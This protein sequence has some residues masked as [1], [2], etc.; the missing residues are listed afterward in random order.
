MKNEIGD[1]K[2]FFR[3]IKYSPGW[4]DDLREKFISYLKPKI[5]LPLYGGNYPEEIKKRIILSAFEYINKVDR[6]KHPSHFLQDPANKIPSAVTYSVEAQKVLSEKYL[7]CSNIAIL[8]QNLLAEFKIPTELMV[9]FIKN[10]YVKEKDEKLFYDERFWGENIRH[11]FLARHDAPSINLSDLIIDRSI[12]Y[13]GWSD[14]TLENLG[15][16]EARPIK[17]LSKEERILLEKE[18]KDRSTWTKN[19]MIFHKGQYHL[20]SEHQSLKNKKFDGKTLPIKSESEIRKRFFKDGFFDKGISVEALNKEGFGFKHLNR[21]I[22]ARTIGQPRY[23]LQKNN[24][25]PPSYFPSNRRMKEILWGF[26]LLIRNDDFP[27]LLTFLN[28]NSVFYIKSIFY[29]YGDAVVWI[30]IDREKHCLEIPSWLINI[31]KRG[32]DQFTLMIKKRE[33]DIICLDFGNDP[34]KVCQIINAI[35]SIV[36]KKIWDYIP[37]ARYFTIIEENVPG[38]KIKG[39]AAESRHILISRDNIFGLAA[40]YGK[41]GKDEWFANIG[42]GSRSLLIEDFYERLYREVRNLIPGSI[43]EYQEKVYITLVR[44]YRRWLQFI[45]KAKKDCNFERNVCA[46]D[47]QHVYNEEKNTLEPYLIEL[48]NHFHY[49]GLSEISPSAYGIVSEIM[50]EE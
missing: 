43:K 22:L 30:R 11:F 21:F 2:K 17:S 47:I 20:R 46:F 15:Y 42:K 28:A 24:L 49:D 27:G 5:D 23:I 40:E 26:P 18:A 44:S 25:T 50:E 19:L 12:P 32:F 45:R 41:I 48:S 14:K 34:G 7:F 29:G 9:T 31:D 37:D 3:G 4:C 1:F 13:G 38:I 10:D 16:K 33:K 36:S 6:L 35:A 8:V 39:F